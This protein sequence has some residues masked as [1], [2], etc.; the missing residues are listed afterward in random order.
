MLTRFISA[1]VVS[2][3]LTIPIQSFGQEQVPAGEEAAIQATLKMI[4]EVVR[5]DQ[6]LNNGLA[7]R[8]AHA[9][10][11]GC[12]KAEFQVAQDVPENLKVGVFKTEKTYPAWIRFS[13]G[14]G[15]IQAD[16]ARDGRG[17]AVK[18]M[19]VD[20]EKILESE[21]FEK[22]QDFIMINNP[23]F[24]VRNAV[25]YVE[26]Q[27][28]VSAG[29][30]FKYFFPGVDPRG[31]RL[32]ELGPAI[33]TLSHKVKNPLSTRYWSMTPYLLGNTEIKYS[34]RPAVCPSGAKAV[35]DSDKTET[36]NFLRENLARSLA[37]SEACFDFLVQR[38]TDPRSMP[39]EDPTVNWSERKSVPVKVATIVIH[40]QSFATAEQ[41]NFCENLSYTPWHALPEHRPL[42]GINRARKVVYEGISKL[43]HDLNHTER[44]EPTGW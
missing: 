24:F 11:H 1:L 16:S 6:A 19:R 28:F 23:D 43:R 37:A 30:P 42:G 34:V 32:H 10:H 5:H 3:F 35:V 25:D 13:N 27:Q 29:K 22:T 41:M 9:K 26:F 14:S 44:R 4:E 8:D 12:V 38:R 2:M 36:P 20:G 18:L 40:K 31:W 39:I 7:V 21:R 15:Q 33:K 17:M